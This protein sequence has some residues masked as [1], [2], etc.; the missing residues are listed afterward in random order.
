MIKIC[1]NALQILSRPNKRGGIQSV[2]NTLSVVFR[3]LNTIERRSEMSV[4]VIVHEA[5]LPK[6][7]LP[8]VVVVHGMSNFVTLRAILYL[9]IRL[10]LM[11][12][13]LRVIWQPHYHP[14][15]YHRYP[16]FAKLYF[17]LL[18]YFYRA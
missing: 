5:L 18:I 15:C 17:F 6:G 1:K 9:L 3:D 13:P 10:A 2:A 4:S 7:L 12:P 8:E 14:F 16:V 11:R